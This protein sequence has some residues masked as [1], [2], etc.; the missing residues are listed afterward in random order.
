L[1]DRAFDEH[2]ISFYDGMSL[3]VSKR[4]KLTVE[5][6]PFFEGK[7]LKLPARFRPDPACISRSR[8]QLAQKD[9]A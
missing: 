7:Q 4:L 2:L 5:N 8:D 9:R 6:R 1:H 3:I